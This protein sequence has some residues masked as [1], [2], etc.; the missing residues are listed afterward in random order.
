MAFTNVI[1]VAILIIILMSSVLCGCVSHKAEFFANNSNI[2]YVDNKT[3]TDIIILSPFFRN[4]TPTDLYARGRASSQEE[5]AQQYMES[6]ITF[7]DDE[8]DILEK[9]ISQANDLLRSFPKLQLA[10][11]NFAKVKASI[12]NGYPHTIGN[13]IVLNERVLRYPIK[14]LTKTLIHEKIHVAQRTHPIDFMQLYESIEFKKTRVA[15]RHTLARA[16]PDIDNF[17]YT[18]KS[19][20]TVPMQLYTSKYPSSIA[21]SVA[22]MVSSNGDSV[23]ATKSTFGLPEDIHCQL[24]HP[25]EIVACLMAEMITNP[26]LS[27]I[28]KN[29]NLS[30]IWKWMMQN[31]K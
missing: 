18:Y 8:K 6:K 22:M 27:Y 29:G 10:P 5:Y 11:W 21:D 7:S 14:E 28:E 3:F 23:E 16:N 24:E 1:V 2:N 20:D 12:E 25:N 19:T 17:L 4:L 15:S 30:T 13:T 31:W 9:C 26:D